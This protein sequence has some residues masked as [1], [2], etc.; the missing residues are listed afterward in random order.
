MLVAFSPVFVA[1]TKIIPVC[2]F[3]APLTKGYVCKEILI[4]DICRKKHQ[5]FQS[6]YMKIIDS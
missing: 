6:F 4:E 2:N 3:V 5:S 1:N